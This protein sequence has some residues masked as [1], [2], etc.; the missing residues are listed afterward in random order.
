M[1][2]TQIID[3][4]EQAAAQLGMEVRTEKGNF[5]GGRCTVDGEQII[6]LNQRHLPETQLVV[7]ADA[8][9]DAAID[10]VYLKPAVRQALVDA[11]EDLDARPN[12]PAEE[13][14]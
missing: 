8:L 1:E 4:L 10:T 11:W 3:E 5:R 12:E 14:S 9:R 7:L 2:T 13:P 6:M